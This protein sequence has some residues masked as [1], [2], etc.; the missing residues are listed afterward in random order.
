[1]HSLGR[2][3]GGWGGGR[4]GRGGEGDVVVA[5]G[6]QPEIGLAGAHVVQPFLG[7]QCEWLGLGGGDEIG[8]Y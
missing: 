1:M 7:A 4:G 5:A 8:S 3:G 6:T 2:G